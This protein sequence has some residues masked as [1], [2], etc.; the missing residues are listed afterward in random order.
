MLDSPKDKVWGYL[1]HVEKWSEWDTEIAK[2]KLRGKFQLNAKGSF[3][4]KGGP[5][6]YFQI[7]EVTTNISYT[8]KTKIPFCCLVVKRTL[9]PKKNNRRI[10]L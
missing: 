7:T 8:F 4:P 5:K 10:E 3:K 2:S 1:T 6:L 9:T